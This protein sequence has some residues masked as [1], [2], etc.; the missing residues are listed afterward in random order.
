MIGLFERLA[1]SGPLPPNFFPTVDIF[2]GPG[3]LIIWFGL[4]AV[5][6]LIF[7]FV[8]NHRWLKYMYVALLA[9]FVGFSVIVL[10]LAL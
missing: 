6:V 2:R 10:W 4:V 8:L 3:R 9:A 7:Q 1:V 5:M